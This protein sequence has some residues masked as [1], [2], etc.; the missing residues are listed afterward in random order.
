M[1]RRMPIPSP[2]QLG[3][4]LV[5]RAEESMSIN[6]K[7]PCKRLRPRGGLDVFVA[8]TYWTQSN[9][10]ESSSCLSRF[11]PAH[12]SSYPKIPSASPAARAEYLPPGGDEQHAASCYQERLKGQVRLGVVARRSWDSP[13]T[14]NL[15][16]CSKISALSWGV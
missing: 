14:G 9:G 4:V 2:R 15:E 13:H 5:L 12:A 11:S 7:L 8:Y 6:I 16:R 10:L 3:W 1:N